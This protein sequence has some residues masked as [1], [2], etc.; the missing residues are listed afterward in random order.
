MKL[1]NNRNIYTWEFDWLHQI[2]TNMSLA[3]H[4]HGKHEKKSSI[5]EHQMSSNSD[6]SLS[7]ICCLI[8]GMW[9]MVVMDKFFPS[10][11]A[12]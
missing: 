1:M 4:L 7:P 5:I 8:I 12:E 10:I 11:P 9:R 6:W 2:P 3:F